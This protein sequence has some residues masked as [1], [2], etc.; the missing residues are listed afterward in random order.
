MSEVLSSQLTRMG[1]AVLVC[2]RAPPGPGG[3][4]GGAHV[5]HKADFGNAGSRIAA[6]QID[7]QVT[8]LGRTKRGASGI[9]KIDGC[10]PGH[11]VPDGVDDDDAV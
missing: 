6:V 1:P 2:S 5:S 11:G 7:W 3:G 8:C 9:S 4:P 10:Q